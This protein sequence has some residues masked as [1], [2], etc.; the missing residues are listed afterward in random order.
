MRIRPFLAALVTSFLLLA[1][2][3]YAAG[4]NC[5]RD[6]SPLV[7]CDVS[8]PTQPYTT[9]KASADVGTGAASDQLARL[10]Q[11][12]AQ[13]ARTPRGLSALERL[14]QWNQAMGKQATVLYR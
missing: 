8:V 4:A 10:R 5:P 2:G 12:S 11:L 6:V 9:A 13:L 14:R 3:G 7:K 1:L